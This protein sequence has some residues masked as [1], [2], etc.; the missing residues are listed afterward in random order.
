MVVHGN[1]LEKREGKRNIIADFLV[2]IYLV[3]NQFKVIIFVRKKYKPPNKR[4]HK[5]HKNL[6]LLSITGWV[7]TRTKG[8]HKVRLG[9]KQ[10]RSTVVIIFYP[11]EIKMIS[12]PENCCKCKCTSCLFSL[13]SGRMLR[14]QNFN[15]ICKDK[16]YC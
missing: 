10:K 8:D 5:T 15:S 4:T 2:L 1:Y 13:F 11:K 3:Q 14:R 6:Q 9:V 12:L 7:N 16:S